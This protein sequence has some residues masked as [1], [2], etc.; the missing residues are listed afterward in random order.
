MS[1]EK[2][3]KANQAQPDNDVSGRDYSTPFPD[4]SDDF[5]EDDGLFAA[6]A[7]ASES[8]QTDLVPED[9]AIE[10]IAIEDVAAE[11][12][13]PEDINLGV[14]ISEADILAETPS[15]EEIQLEAPDANIAATLAQ[16][17]DSVVKDNQETNN[18]EETQREETSD[19]IAAMSDAEIS[20]SEDTLPNDPAPSPDNADDVD[21]SPED[22]ELTPNKEANIPQDI[23]TMPEENLPE[24]NLPEENLAEENL[25]PNDSDI[26]TE[27]H[28]KIAR[29]HDLAPPSNPNHTADPSTEKIA[30]EAPPITPARKSVKQ[31]HG[32]GRGLDALLGPDDTIISNVPDDN[33]I[34]RV[35][36]N[37]LHP[38]PAQPRKIFDEDLLQQLIAS[39]EE[40]GVL[41]PILVRPH[42]A[43]ANRYE[44]VAGERRWRAALQAK[45]INVPIIVKDMTDG[46]SLEIAL[47]ENIQRTDLT[48]MEEADGYQ[49]LMQK[50]DYTQE[51]LAKIMGKSRSHIANMVRLL[52]L[53]DEIKD[54]INT[55]S[56]SA[57]HGRALIGHENAAEL[58]KSLLQKGLMF[59]KPNK[60]YKEIKANPKMLF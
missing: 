15:E 35:P 42:P 24:E 29:E 13:A 48:P 7:D 3:D 46:D 55:E 43:Q 6:P 9:I 32:L 14:N 27:D 49:T 18:A 23:T 60:W 51:S 45:Q 34:K 5:A 53:P 50:F 30:E 33:N 11:D 17:L 47:I 2:R 19:A 54:M 25:P 20:V 41:Q 12:V 37:L 10:D 1:N 44:I 40:K 58:G 8:D 31:K 28:A 39:I 4:Q 52:T 59:D 26:L 36:P 38:N 21:T 57:G 16:D 22:D 56:L